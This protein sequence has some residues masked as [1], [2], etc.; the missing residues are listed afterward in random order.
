VPIYHATADH[1]YRNL[2]DLQSQRNADGTTPPNVTEQGFP[3][4]H[5]GIGSGYAPNEQGIPNTLS[6]IP[7]QWMHNQ[8]VAAGAPLAP[9]PEQYQVPPAL[10]AL[11]NEYRAGNPVAEETLKENYIH[12]SR[13]FWERWLNDQQRS[14][15]YPNQQSTP[16]TNNP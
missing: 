13:Y 15:F 2:F 9:I 1:E 5:A 4:A 8:A 11:Y 3:G 16:T 12:D 7:L 10:Q 6:T 14:V